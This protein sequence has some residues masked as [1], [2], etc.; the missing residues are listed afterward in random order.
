M[1]LKGKIVHFLG[2]SIT[3]GVGTSDP[4]H[5]YLNVLKE[6]AG[7]AEANNYG[8]SGTRI[9]E[10]RVPTD[11]CPTFDLFFGSRV[12]GMKDD[13][14][15]IVVYGGVNDWGHGDALIGRM[16]DR[17]TNTFYGGLHYLIGKLI[18]KYPRAQLVFI[19]P[20]HCCGEQDVHVKNSADGTYADHPVLDDYV[21]II[22]EVCEY[23]SIPICDFHRISGIQPNVDLIREMYCPD[24]LHPNDAGHRLMAAKLEGF[25]RTL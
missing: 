4:S 15:I 6:S 25:L 8:I 12:E 11:Y 16:S 7:L 10:Q 3:E 18:A 13:A 14:D 17:C 22:R 9:A 2:D 1:E 5:I 19:T 21:K 20:L 23:Y 24:G